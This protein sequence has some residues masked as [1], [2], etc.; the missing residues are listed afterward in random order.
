MTLRSIKDD[1]GP[2][3]PSM[4]IYG[5]TP[6]VAEQSA[7][8]LISFSTARTLVGLSRSKIYLLMAVGEFPAPVKIGRNNYFSVQELQAWISAQLVARPKGGQ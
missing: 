8:R 5:H 1:V 2:K 7:D 4:N 3:E 6:E